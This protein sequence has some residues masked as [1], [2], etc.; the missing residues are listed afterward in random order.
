MLPLVLALSL[1][2]MLAAAPARA[3]TNLT[4]LQDTLFIGYDRL[5]RPYAA[6]NK[7]VIQCQYKLNKFNGLDPLA[8]TFE[9]DL[10]LRLQWVDPRLVF[11][12][13]ILDGE[14][15]HV[16][17][18]LAWT[19]DIYFYNEAAEMKTL[20]Y[21]FKL[22]AGGLVFWSR[23]FIM[24]MAADLDLALFPFDTQNLE[25][26][27]VSYAFD[28][29]TL[30]LEWFSTGAVYPDP[31]SDPTAPLKSDIWT[32]QDIANVSGSLTE[33]SG[34]TDYSFLAVSI[35]AK[36]IPAYYI[37]RYIVPIFV[38]ALAS[39]AQYWIDPAAVSTRI[40][41]GVTLLLAVV[42]FM[43]I[44]ST[45]LPKVSYNT[46]MDK[47]V[48]TCFFFIFFGLIEFALVHWISGDN[49]IG[50]AEKE[51]DGS[52]LVAP[53]NWFPLFLDS[54]LRFIQPV[55]VLATTILCFVDLSPGGIAGLS[56]AFVLVSLFVSA[57]VYYDVR[58][59]GVKVVTTAD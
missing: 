59:L 19:P 47:F 26:Q 57:W 42:S 53:K 8:G 30:L 14:A 39:S 32:I 51:A 23:H 33:I 20:D 6:E 55:A 18:S 12:T 17:P 4:E 10:Y 24:T 43:F 44:L 37:T 2:L 45:D 5:A 31:M 40:G 50:E 3:F 13:S 22:K 29:S 58:K 54:S 28:N 48:L 7:T 15:F 36:R 46:S 11:N 25:L 49:E 9:M 1:L 16:D 52:I 34:Q 27:L 38:L 35:E 41:A 56:V 21:S